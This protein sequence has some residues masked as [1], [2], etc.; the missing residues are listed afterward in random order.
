MRKKTLIMALAMIL[1]MAFS[2]VAMA[3][4]IMPLWDN[5][6]SC[7]PS[8]RIS[9]SNAYCT[10]N[11]DAVDSSYKITATVTLQKLGSNGKYG[12]VDDWS[13]LSGTGKLRFSGTGTASA[14][15]SYRIKCD[16]NVDG[17]PI[18]VYAYA[19]K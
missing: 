2:S 18:T 4:D 14:S 17:E 8:L 13:G 16:V 7:Q 5:A 19:T 3:A 9:G 10:L 12:Y 6:N 1:A 15:G 11:V